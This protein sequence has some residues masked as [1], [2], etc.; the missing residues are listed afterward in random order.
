ML[1]LAGQK[2]LEFGIGV[3]HKCSLRFTQ[4]ASKE[5]VDRALLLLM[6]AFGHHDLPKPQ[7]KRAGLPAQMRCIA[8]K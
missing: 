3:L 2:I 8:Q 1:E 4:Q 6:K 5:D 7:Q